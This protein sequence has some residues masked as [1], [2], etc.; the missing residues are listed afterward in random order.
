[1]NSLK[2]K[3]SAVAALAGVL[4]ISQPLYAQGRFHDGANFFG[5]SFQT[6]R[7]ARKLDLNDEQ[8]KQYR[9]VIDAARPEADEL[10]DATLANRHALREL[11][12]GTALSEGEIQEIADLRGRLVSRMIVLKARVHA[13]IHALLTPDQRERFEKLQSRRKGHGHRRHRPS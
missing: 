11:G 1:M 6:A 3:V 10:A 2:A 13:Q 4:A 7:F 9:E 12:K 8:R 5:S